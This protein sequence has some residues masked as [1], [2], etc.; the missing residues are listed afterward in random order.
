MLAPTPSAAARLCRDLLL[1]PNPNWLV[2]ACFRST[3]MSSCSSVSGRV[4]AILVGHHT[5]CD[6]FDRRTFVLMAGSFGYLYCHCSG[7]SAEI[8]SIVLG[9]LLYRVGISRDSSR[10]R[11][12]ETCQSR[13][14]QAVGHK[15][16]SFGFLTRLRETECSI[17]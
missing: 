8:Q 4:V 1:P 15:F 17:A 7:S 2:V 11:H 6:V 3:A 12:F 5:D 16:R 13:S 14:P 9:A 10:V